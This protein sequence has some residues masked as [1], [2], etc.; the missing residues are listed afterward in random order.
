MPAP[1]TIVTLA[2]DDGDAFPFSLP[3][4]YKSNRAA[5]YEAALQL[6][7][8]AIRDGNITPNGD[9]LPVSIEYV[10]NGHAV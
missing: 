8:E 10:G 7:A 5:D 9:L 6:A 2:D 3:G 1:M 4:V